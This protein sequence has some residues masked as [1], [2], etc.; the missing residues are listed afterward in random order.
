MGIIIP[1]L[2]IS[3]DAS[4]DQI[5]E[6]AWSRLGNHR[7]LSE[8]Q[9]SQKFRGC[10][11]KSVASPEARACL[12]VT[13]PDLNLLSRVS[14]PP[15]LPHLSIPPRS[16]LCL[17]C[18]ELPWLLSLDLSGNCCVSLQGLHFRSQRNHFY[19]CFVIKLGFF[20]KKGAGTMWVHI[21]HHCPGDSQNERNYIYFFFVKFIFIVFFPLPFIPLIPST[22]TPL[23][24]PTQSPHCIHVYEFFFLF[25]RSHH[26]LT[27]PTRTVSLLSMSLFLFCLLVQ[28]FH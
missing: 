2:P 24:P 17:G 11:K 14:L 15:S 6:H 12:R 10:F 3:Q 9:G 16:F 21:Y 19:M 26:P 4:E 23:P 5:I 27:A 28:F 8:Q 20:G 18:S 22:S 13:L 1:A 7:G 25:A